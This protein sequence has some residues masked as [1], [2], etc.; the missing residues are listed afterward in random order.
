MLTVDKWLSI[1]G[2]C[3]DLV[4]ELDTLCK[5]NVLYTFIIISII[6]VNNQFEYHFVVQ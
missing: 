5:S 1:A 2:V 3:W 6:Y 4:L